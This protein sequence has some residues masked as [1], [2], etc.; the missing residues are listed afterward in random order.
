MPR[1]CRPGRSLRHTCCTIAVAH[2]PN[3]PAGGCSLLPLR[4]ARTA[5]YNN[6]VLCALNTPNPTWDPSDTSHL[7]CGQG[8]AL[9]TF[10]V[11]LV[12]TVL[13]V[14][15]NEFFPGLVR[16]LKPVLPLIG[17]ALTTLL[18]ASPC[19]Q[20]AA[21]LRWAAQPDRT[22]SPALFKIA[23]LKTVGD[24]MACLVV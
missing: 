3:R 1:A 13:G 4:H 19:A 16:R 17:V 5:C 7:L 14:A 23:V 15:T 24:A 22:S 20:V 8:L 21:I 18:C 9:S 11:V 12:P 10:Q 2:I 6:L